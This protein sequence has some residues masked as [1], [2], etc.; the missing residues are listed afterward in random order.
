MLQAFLHNSRLSPL[1]HITL[2]QCVWH[3]HLTRCHRSEKLKNGY[4][5]CQP[6]STPGTGLLNHFACPS[7][8]YQSYNMF[9]HHIDDNCFILWSFST[10][11]LQ[12]WKLATIVDFAIHFTSPVFVLTIFWEHLFL[13]AWGRYLW[14]HSS[15][16][17]MDWTLPKQ[18]GYVN[19]VRV[20]YWASNS[21]SIWYHIRFQSFLINFWNTIVSSSITLDYKNRRRFSRMH[22]LETF[23]SM[24]MRHS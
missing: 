4:R 22:T 11:K 6:L 15:D 21:W 24:S 9:L 3:Q 14:L 17:Y 7:A 18:P 2:C 12:V 8:S 19:C 5:C 13:S 16:L 20:I 10:P 1:Q 23:L